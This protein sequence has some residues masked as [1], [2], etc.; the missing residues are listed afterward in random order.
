MC[1]LSFEVCLSN[2]YKIMLV[3]TNAA[4]DKIAG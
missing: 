2:N 1:L 3:G 4:V